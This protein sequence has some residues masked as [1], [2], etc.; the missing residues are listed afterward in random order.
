[1]HKV[2]VSSTPS[3]LVSCEETPLHSAAEAV[4]YSKHF[5]EFTCAGLSIR[6]RAFVGTAGRA[7]PPGR[8]GAPRRTKSHPGAA[9]G[10]KKGPI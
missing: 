6:L 10:E 3:T 7:Q 5:Y 1:M 4:S 2:R 9:E 8:P